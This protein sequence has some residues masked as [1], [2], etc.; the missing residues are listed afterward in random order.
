MLILSDRFIPSKYPPGRVETWMVWFSLDR[1]KAEKG[2]GKVACVI[3]SAFLL[4]EKQ[5]PIGEVNIDP[6]QLWFSFSCPL[7]SGCQTPVAI[8]NRGNNK[9]DEHL[10]RFRHE[11][12]CRIFWLLVLP[13]NL[14]WGRENAAFCTLLPFR[15]S[16]RTRLEN[17]VY[18]LIAN[19][20]PQFKLWKQFSI[21]I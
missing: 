19:Y 3:V 6:P 21:N 10:S 7:L 17:K 11:S 12:I 1:R 9:G 8:Q 20:V 2:K 18:L 5:N 14:P 15:A 4:K 13:P 16:P